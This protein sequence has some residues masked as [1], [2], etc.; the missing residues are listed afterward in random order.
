MRDNGQDTQAK[1]RKLRRNERGELCAFLDGEKDP[2][3]KARVA[4]CFPWSLGDEY[5]SVRDG[6]G[7]EIVL[8]KTLDE[9]DPDTRK[10]IEQELLDTVFVPRIRSITKYSD[11]FDVISITAE[12]DRG[13]VTFQIR[14]RQDVRILS[15]TRAVFRDVDG[16][17]YEV[18]DINALDRASKRHIESYF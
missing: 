4:R 13:E 5:I 7:K 18:P 16:N 6:E 14:E 3:A 10:L 2:V 17:L 8:L 9:V 11:E 15:A 12:T 1:L